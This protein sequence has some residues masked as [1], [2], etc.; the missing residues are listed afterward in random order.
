M[1]LGPQMTQMITDKEDIRP[2]GEG[3]R[4]KMSE[5]ETRRVV[6]VSLSLFLSIS[7]SLHHFPGLR[8]DLR[9]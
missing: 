3:A 1:K 9:E 4:G 5:R 7:P 2:K 8:S 6:A